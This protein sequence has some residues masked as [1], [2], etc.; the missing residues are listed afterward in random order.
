MRDRTFWPVVTCFLLS[1]FAALIY[2]TAWTR[3]FAFV[4]GTSELAVATVLAAYM[5]GLAGGAWLAGRLVHRV[6]RP[7]LVYGVLEACI[8]LAAIAVPFAIRG[9]TLLYVSLFGGRADLPPSSGTAYA[10]YFLASSFLILLV[11]TALMGATLPLLARH[12][13]HTRSQIGSRIGSLYAANTVGAVAGTLCAAFWLIPGYGLRLTV[14]VAVAANFVVFG[15]A[16]FVARTAP[17]AGTG[18]AAVARA[19]RGF[20]WI[21]PAILLS[22]AVSFSYEVF[23]FRLLSHV[24][25]GSVHAFATML[26]SFLIGIAIGSAFAAR[27]ATDPSRAA[28]GFAFAQLGIAVL[29]LAAYLLLDRVPGLAGALTRVL[30]RTASDSLVSIAV[31]LPS[32]LCIGATFPFAVRA[33]AKDPEDASAATARVYAWNTIGAIAGSLGAGYFLIPALGFSGMLSVALA[34]SAVL[35]LTAALFA[36]PRA[37]ALAASAALVLAAAVVFRPE[38]P[39]N[40]LRTGPVSQDRQQG[41][42]AFH[43]VGRTATVLLLDQGAQWGLRTNGL[44]EASVGRKHA[45]TMKFGSGRWLSLLPTLARPDARN[46]LVIGLGGGVAVE[47]MPPTIETADVIEIE[48]QVIEANRT[49][50]AERRFDP[51]A[52][53]RIRLHVNDARGALELSDL[54]FDAIISQPS[55][56]WTAGASHLYSREFFR[57]AQRHLRPGG[58]L[59]QWMGSSFVDEPLLRSL[60]ATLSD[61]F[62]H[63]LVFLP[64]VAGEFAFVASDEPLD[65][66]DSAARAIAADPDF[67]ARFGIH[68]PEDIA[69]SLVLDEDGVRRWAEGAP[70]SRD[71]HNLLETL[72]PGVTLGSRGLQPT[73]VV[74]IIGADDAIIAMARKLDPIALAEAAL[75]Q[76]EH[77]R[78]MRLAES[79]ASPVAR[80]TVTGLLAL[81]SGQAQRAGEELSAALALDREEPH[82]RA[83]LL[84]LRRRVFERSPASI[85]VLEPLTAAESAISEAWA[86]GDGPDSV[87]KL[88]ALDERLAAVPPTHP[89]HPDALRLRARWR[90]DRARADDTAVALELLDDAIATGARPEDFLLRARAVLALGDAAEAVDSVEQVLFWIERNPAARPLAHQALALLDGL[91]IPEAEA[92]LRAQVR[93]RLEKS[94]DRA[95]GEGTGREESAPRAAE[96]PG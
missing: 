50:S 24:L 22:G 61:T 80:R 78:V 96:S 21:L 75:A 69:A 3:E 1:G 14:V 4:F 54:R 64:Y 33:V 11:P 58:V 23:W 44:P 42:V 31:L 10:V 15:I 66:A 51:L 82:A 57:L 12:A 95:A 52:D 59:V 32:T 26:A 40:L 91:E 46:L 38:P 53:P 76:T 13:V 63:V 55:H 67:F 6:T 2:Q 20:H 56:P 85:A 8:A 41:T 39:W 62:P 74:K 94:I 92:A 77:E 35:A 7:V 49:M 18:G 72:S 5:G 28:R 37:L 79:L 9:A 48:P 87:A 25:G 45:R 16:A 60:L 68:R 90:I 65:I 43:A 71:D 17:P 88:A 89:F 29:S 81:A 36:R 83:G 70:V 19:S 47:L 34:A 73:K 84:R 93:G 30:G 86:A 27:A